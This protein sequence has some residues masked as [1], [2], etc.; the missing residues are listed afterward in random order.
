[1]STPNP[2]DHLGPPVADQDDLN[3]NYYNHNLNYISRGDQ[4]TGLDEYLETI[5]D[6]LNNLR[7]AINH[8]RSFGLNSVDRLILGGNFN[9]QDSVGTIHVLAA[10]RGSISILILVRK[11]LTTEPSMPI[12]FLV[13]LTSSLRVVMSN[14]V[15]TRLIIW[16]RMLTIRSLPTLLVVSVPPSTIMWLPT[17]DTP[18]DTATAD[19][20]VSHSQQPDLI[21]NQS[22]RP[23]TSTTILPVSIPPT[24]ICLGPGSP[25]MISRIPL[26]STSLISTSWI[27]I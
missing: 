12:L 10:M 6:L 23:A 2:T 24:S 16:P 26:P 19:G 3:Y 17:H 11:T 14:L 15:P 27:L 5:S 21:N 18:L 9:H 4:F 1:M 8:Q 25:L 20:T 13:S 7:M 22:P